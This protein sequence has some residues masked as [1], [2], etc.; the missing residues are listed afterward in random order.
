MWI[1]ASAPESRFRSAARAGGNAGAEERDAM[2]TIASV[3]NCARARRLPVGVSGHEVRNPRPGRGP[4]RSAE[5]SRRAAYAGRAGVG[6]RSPHALARAAR[7]GGGRPAEHRRGHGRGHDGVPD[8]ADAE[9]QEPDQGQGRDLH[10]RLLQR[11]PVPAGPRRPTVRPL[12]PEHRRRR[13]QRG[14]LPALRE[15]RRGGRQ[16]RRVA[17]ER[18]LPDGLRRQVHERLRRQRPRTA[19]LDLLRRTRRA[20]ASTTTTSSTRTAGSSATARPA[21]TTAPRSSRGR[22]WRSWTS[23]GS[24]ARPSS[25]WWKRSRRTCPRRPWAPTWRRSRAR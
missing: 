21:P 23:P 7:G 20:A 8:R 25:W 16:R 11:S 2:P 19:G 5:G 6:R 22:P 18:E 17:E 13:Q 9:H 15:Q 14:Q 1:M 10:P 24:P 12:R 3:W 4:R